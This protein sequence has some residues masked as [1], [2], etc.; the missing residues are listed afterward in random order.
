MTAKLTQPGRP[1]IPASG[2]VFTNGHERQ[3]ANR[4]GKLDCNIID[5][6]ERTAAG[7]GADE[8]W[9]GRTQALTCH[10][11]FEARF[12]RESDSRELSRNSFAVG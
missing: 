9:E 2:I 6:G 10:L 11:D 12:A 1:D 7:G 5:A 8:T 3:V 4:I